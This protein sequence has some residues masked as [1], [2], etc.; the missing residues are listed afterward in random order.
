MNIHQPLAGTTDQVTI[1]GQFAGLGYWTVENF[2]FADGTTGSAQDVKQTLLDQESAQ[3]GGSVLGYA[4]S[5][6]TLVAG[7]GD[8]YLA[9]EGGADPQIDG[10]AVPHRHGR[11][12][13]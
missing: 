8:K 11:S 13:R 10:A 12:H 6:D 1:Q 9:G 7:L 2:H 4:N 3:T 5:N